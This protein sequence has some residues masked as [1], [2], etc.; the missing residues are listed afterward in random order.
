MAF[1]CYVGDVSRWSSSFV[2]LRKTQARCFT[3]S[4][5]SCEQDERE[6]KF[7]RFGEKKTYCSSSSVTAEMIAGLLSDGGV[8]FRWV[9][10]SLTGLCNFCYFCVLIL[11]TPARLTAAI[12]SKLFG[13]IFSLSS[14]EKQQT[15]NSS[16]SLCA[17]NPSGC[18][19]SSPNH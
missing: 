15:S 13:F 16:K 9:I 8:S 19:P 3:W 14:D 4:L 7:E 18:R 6:T 2:S 12:Q 17:K 5:S 11:L 10:I 1:S